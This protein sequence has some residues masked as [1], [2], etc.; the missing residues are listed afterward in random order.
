[1]GRKSKKQ[2]ASDT[3][4]RGALPSTPGKTTALLD[5]KFESCMHKLVYLDPHNHHLTMLYCISYDYY[6]IILLLYRTTYHQVHKKFHQLDH[7]LSDL[8]SETRTWC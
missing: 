2:I 7:H 3:N 8:K 4:G 5:A 6:Y 1:M